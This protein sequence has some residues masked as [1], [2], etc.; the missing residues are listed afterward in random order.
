MQPHASTRLLRME[1][2][3]LSLLEYRNDTELHLRAVRPASAGSGPLL[4]VKP[5]AYLLALR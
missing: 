3:H 4:D 5:T 2:L 1:V